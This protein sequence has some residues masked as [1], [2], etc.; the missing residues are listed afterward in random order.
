MVYITNFNCNRYK[1]EV[2][3]FPDRAA[4]HQ[5]DSCPE[6]LKDYSKYELPNELKFNKNSE[7][8]FRSWMGFSYGGRLD[9]M[10]SQEIADELSLIT[11]KE[12]SPDFITRIKN[13]GFTDVSEEFA[14]SR[15][16]KRCHLCWIPKSELN[17]D[18]L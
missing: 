11:D 7:W 4:Y 18:K 5:V 13:S 10:S 15:G 9:T 3:E 8:V 2:V 6:L 14:I 1:V 16:F 12:I 17:A